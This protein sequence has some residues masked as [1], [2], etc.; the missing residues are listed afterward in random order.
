MWSLI[1]YVICICLSRSIIDIEQ[2]QK[3]NNHTGIYL[4]IYYIIV[5]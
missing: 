3:K 4:R 1:L 2:T 5:I